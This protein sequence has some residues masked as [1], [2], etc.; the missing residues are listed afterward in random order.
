MN[1]NYYPNVSGKP[2]VM[3][4]QGTQPP[5]TNMPNNMQNFSNSQLL[6]NPPYAEN[7]LEMNRGKKA[8]FFM[9]YSDSIEWRDRVFEGIIEDA[10]R[11]YTL[12]RRLD[13]DG[14]VLLWNVY[15][16]FVEFDEP[17]NH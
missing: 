14:R 8:R 12:L 6:G 16:N 1:N 10:G 2:N 15:L 9:S 3:P 13:S 4:N 7:I 5:I 11:D 17:I